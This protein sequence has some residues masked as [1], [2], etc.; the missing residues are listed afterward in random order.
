LLAWYPGQT[1]GEIMDNRPDVVKSV[2]SRQ[3]LQQLHARLGRMSVTAVHDFY[4]AAYLTC[5]LDG[6]N[7]PKPRHV[8][9]LVAAWKEMYACGKIRSR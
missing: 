9:E 8:Q 4:G 1:K 7:I 5:R 2:L 3:D 6:H